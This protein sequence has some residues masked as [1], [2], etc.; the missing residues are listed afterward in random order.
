MNILPDTEPAGPQAMTIRR[1]FP[2]FFEGFEEETAAFS[3]IAELEAVSFVATWLENPEFHRLSLTKDNH[4]MCELKGG[5][6]WFVVGFITGGRPNLPQPVFDIP[7]P[8]AIKLDDA[9][10]VALLGASMSIHETDRFAYSVSKLLRYERA[11]L[12]VPTAQAREAL[13]DII[14]AIQR[15]AGPL[16]PI[17]I[18]D[19]LVLG[20]V[21]DEDAIK[22]ITPG[23]AGF[24]RP[25][26]L[27]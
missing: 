15:E 20:L 18:N 26:G 16:A 21:E 8:E 25:N 2:A 4:L 3:T 24:R 19:E 1:Y 5:R 22:I 27:R 17:F 10:D 6:E 9:Y 23:S 12:N 7:T 11:R 14:T 13:A